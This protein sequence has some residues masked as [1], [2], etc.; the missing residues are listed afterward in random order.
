MTADTPSDTP[1]GANPD[2]ELSPAARKAAEAALELPEEQGGR[3]GPTGLIGVDG[4]G[5]IQLVNKAV[6]EQ[7][8][9]LRD[10]LFGQPIEVLLPEELRAGHVGLRMAFLQRPESRP[11]GAGRD[12]QG[13]RKDG[14]TMPVEVG[15]N[16]IEHGGQ[17]GT[18]ATVAD[19][20]ER[21]AN[22]RRQQI[23]MNEIRHRGR[24]LLTVVQAIASRTLTADRSTLQA[25]IAFMATIDA[26]SRTHDLYLTMTTA[27]LAAIVEAEL[28]PFGDRMTVAGCEVML[29]QSAAQDFALIIHELTTN[30]VKYG[31][32]SAPEGVVAVSARED[33][34]CLEFVWEERGGPPVNPP[35][36]RGFGH[37]IL[38]DVAHGFCVHVAAHYYPD[39]LR[40]ELRAE[41]DRITNLVELSA[42]RTPEATLPV[43][44]TD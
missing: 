22:E 24:N 34:A 19:I 1:R 12:L 10:E 8:G 20:S 26:L 43:G 39:G 31:A 16:P 9:Y 13:L 11:M 18:L 32:L 25:R 7:F 27:P 2:K 40:Y 41:L 37:T 28:A 17:R 38:N 4:E 44:V 5:V 6:E 35:T 33:G 3:K 29:T 15:L 23:L 36:R 30:A 42:R 14:T 21:K